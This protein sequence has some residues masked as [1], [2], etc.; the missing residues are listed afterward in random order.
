VTK[1]TNLFS[2]TRLETG[3][4]AVVALAEAQESGACARIRRVYDDL[5]GLD[6]FVAAV[7]RSWLLLALVD[8]GIRLDGWSAVRVGDVAEAVVSPRDEFVR[9]ALELRGELPLLPA[10]RLKLDSVR[11]LLQSLSEVTLITVMTER[12]GPFACAI[13]RIVEIG[14]RELL[15]L[16][17]DP[18][19]EWEKTPTR[20]DLASITRVDH[21]GSYEQALALVAEARS[22][23]R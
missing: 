14:Q 6:G 20:I 23:D 15:L 7:G 17:I 8:E 18:R 21:G 13:G 5:L 1:N 11:R 19:A 22:R 9:S 2:V 4:S 3:R 10:P 12:A 16:E